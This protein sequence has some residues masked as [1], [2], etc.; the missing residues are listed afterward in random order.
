MYTD[1]ESTRARQDVRDN[2]PLL[3]PAAM[4]RDGSFRRFLRVLPSSVGNPPL[5]VG[6]PAWFVSHVVPPFLLIVITSPVVIF[7]LSILGFER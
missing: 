1:R 6:G 2:T 7:S 3:I 4:S 5:R